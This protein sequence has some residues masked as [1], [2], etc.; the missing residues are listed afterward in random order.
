MPNGGQAHRLNHFF[1]LLA[2][3]KYPVLTIAAL[4]FCDAYG[5]FSGTVAVRASNPIGQ[6]LSVTVTSFAALR[7]MSAGTPP[8]YA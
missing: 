7:S 2:S 5:I 8:E 3:R 4:M 6:T 1:A